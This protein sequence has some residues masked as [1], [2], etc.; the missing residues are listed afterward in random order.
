MNVIADLG[1]WP[2]V[3]YGAPEILRHVA[4]CQFVKERG[5]LALVYVTRLH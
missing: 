3:M 2:N 4:Q 5:R 1:N